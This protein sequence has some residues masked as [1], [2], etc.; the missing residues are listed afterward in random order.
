MNAAVDIRSLSH[1]YGWRWGARRWA[2]RDLDLEV[3]EGSFFGLLG[4]NGAG[5]STTL[6]ICMNLLRPSGGETRVL[7]TPSRSLGPEQLAKIGYVSADQRLPGHLDLDQLFAYLGP[8]YPTWDPAFAD[9]LV[10]QLQV[11]RK[12]KLLQMSRGEKMKAALVSSMAYRPAIL[13]LDEPFSGLDVL[14]RDDLVEGILDP[15]QQEGWTVVISSHDLGGIEPLVDQVGI[16]V[17]GRTILTGAIDELGQRFRQVEVVYDDEAGAPDS[18]PSSWLGFRR[19]GRTARF[20]E[21][22]FESEEALRAAWPGARSLETSNLGLREL[23]VSVC[24][25]PGVRSEV[26]SDSEPSLDSEG[27]EA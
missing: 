26:G 13:I 8:L 25:Q 15:T 11:P 22:R 14:T 17:E 23:F 21:S 6:D 10:R 3:P 16:L 5:K 2:V 19:A 4:P 24:R 12:R 9:Q 20:V 27:K 1:R 7:G 18:L